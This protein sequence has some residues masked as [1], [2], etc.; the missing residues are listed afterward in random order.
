[1]N[2]ETEWLKSLEAL[3]GAQQ[4]EIKQL[5]QEAREEKNHFNAILSDMRRR[6][7]VVEFVSKA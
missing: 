4:A 3:A 7:V 5:K 6:L 2:S 1:M